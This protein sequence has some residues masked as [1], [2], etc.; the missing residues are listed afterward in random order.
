SPTRSTNGHLS[1]RYAYFWRT[2]KVKFLR[3]SLDSKVA[4]QIEREPFWLE[5]ELKDSGSTL[6][7]TNFH[8]RPHDQTP[9]AEIAL[10]ADYPQ[11]VAGQAL[12]S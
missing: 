12:F 7:L 1:E 8:S 10:L 9:E 5:V 3:A 6:W 11:R 2:S 4:E